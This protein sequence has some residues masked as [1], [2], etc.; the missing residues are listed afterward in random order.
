[1]RSCSNSSNPITREE[2]THC[3]NLELSVNLSGPSNMVMVTHSPTA[4]AI[5]EST[6]VINNSWA[7][8]A[9]EAKE[10][11]KVPTKSGKKILRKQSRNS[12]TPRCQVSK[13]SQ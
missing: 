3:D 7:D 10:Q 13:P 5:K 2:P 1:M 4:L 11:A 9:D 8:L 6:A 12:K